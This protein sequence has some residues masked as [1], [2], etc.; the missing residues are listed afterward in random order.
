MNNL[1]KLT[2]AD[3]EAYFYGPYYKR[4]V[5]YYNQNYIFDII[6]R[7]SRLEALCYGSMDTPYRV[8]VELSEKSIQWDDC[9]CPI[10]GGCKHVAAL[11]LNW[12]HQPEAF[13]PKEDSR[14]MLQ[15][16]PKEDLIMLI[17]EML[18]RE[19]DLEI[20]L[21]LPAIR[22]D[23]KGEFVDPEP[24]R[25]Q[26]RNAFLGAEDWNSHFRV[27]IEVSSVVDMADRFVKAEDYHNASAV[28]LVVVEEGLD[29]Y[30]HA[31]HDEGEIL[32][33]ID[34]AI[35][36]LSVCFS[37]FSETSEERSELL[38]TLFNSYAW[39][40]KMGG[41]GFGDQ[42]PVVLAENTSFDEREQIR[43]WIKD[44][45]S[46]QQEA[47]EF[48]SRWRRESWGRLLLLLD[49][50]DG[51]IDGFL[52]RA[53]AQGMHRI[54]FDKLVELGR[55]DEA[56][57][58]AS[59][60]L[61]SSD[62]EF[63]SSAQALEKACYIKRAIAMVETRLSAIEDP[64]LLT[65]LADHYE[66]NNNN[67]GALN[68][69]LR[70][71]KSERPSLEI[72]EILERLGNKLGNWDN[73]ESQLLEGLHESENW[74]VLARVHLYKEQWDLAWD[75]AERSSQTRWGWRPN[76]MEIVAK[77]TEEI[78]PHNAIRFYLGRVQQL[79]DQRGRDNYATAAAYL[80]KVR[81]LTQQNDLMA[82]W[83]DTI[84]RVRENNRNLPAC[85]DELNKAGL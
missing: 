27:S 6:R 5:G 66:A 57:D 63:L 8:V 80:V 67:D 65:W 53:E 31:F 84:E 44:Q 7:G 19:P 48:T 60:H 51:D 50:Q 76:V 14:S 45:A 12:V 52:L 61:V 34:R 73:L 33:E 36:G 58:V 28:Y 64:R 77:A 85:Q 43:V 71:W 42:I 2:E 25:R 21:D 79:I 83:E 20:L 81:R 41:Y 75:V 62:F 3:I 1:P 10:G 72:Y 35:E 69:H 56:V 24:Y 39:D 46:G 4:G 9:S 38:K 22:G 26:V 15:N 18:K 32:Y 78:R 16:R 82:A 49:E 70:C 37:A 11:L 59:H 13:V 47:S 30:E 29:N 17:E 40:V 68:L 74:D 23:A 55:V 54:R